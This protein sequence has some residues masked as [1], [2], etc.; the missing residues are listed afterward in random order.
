MADSGVTNLGEF[1]DF[2]EESME[3]VET[4]ARDVVTKL[5]T[6]LW[7]KIIFKTPVDTGRARQSWNIQWGKPDGSVPPEGEYERMKGDSPNV[8]FPEEIVGQE[9]EV[10]HISSNLNYIKY[11]E[12]GKPGPGSDQAPLGMVETSIQELKIAGI[13]SFDELKRD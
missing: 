13:D 10:L 6:E 12:Q 3:L 4:S 8:N 2:I 9:G 11:L 5:G 1:D 7:R